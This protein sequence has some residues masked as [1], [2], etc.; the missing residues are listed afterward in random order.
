[1]KEGGTRFLHRTINIH[2]LAIVV[3]WAAVQK[4]R[5]NPIHLPMQAPAAHAIPV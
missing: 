5:N 4:E 2:T 1:V 3:D